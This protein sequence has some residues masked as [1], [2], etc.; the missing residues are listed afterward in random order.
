MAT[1][2]EK[3]DGDKHERSALHADRMRVVTERRYR[4]ALQRK[5]RAERLAREAS[6]Q[7]ERQ[8]NARLAKLHHEATLCRRQVAELFAAYRD[9]ELEHVERVR[10]RLVG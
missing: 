9:H 3:F 8:R 10:L 1:T 5:Q 6:T 4:Q 2:P 7:Y